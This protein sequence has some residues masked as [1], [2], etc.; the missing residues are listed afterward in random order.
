MA[1][2]R[3]EGKRSWPLAL[4]T[5]IVVSSSLLAEGTALIKYPLDGAWEFRQVGHENWRPATVP[6]CVHLD[7]MAAGIIPDPF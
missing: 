3:K 4:G 6:G 5:L 1:N 7:L 2:P